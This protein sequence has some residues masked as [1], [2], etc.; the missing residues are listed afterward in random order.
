MAEDR[1]RP[2]GDSTLTD[3]RWQAE[4][5]AVVKAACRGAELGLTVGT[6][7]NVSARV[8]DK[9]FTITPTGASYETMKWDDIVVV[10]HDIEPVAGEGIPSS[11]SLLHSTIYQRRPDIGAVIH[12]HSTYSSVLAVTGQ[13]IPPILDEMVVHIGGAIGVSEYAFPAT[14][15]LA[16]NV[17]EALGD[18]NAAIIRNHGAVAVGKDLDEALYVCQ[19]VE[20]AAH[21]FVY[22]SLLGEASVLPDESVRAEKAIFRMRMQ[23]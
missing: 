22:A 8:S 7:G 19:L 23:R 5:E 21:V 11:E 17:F 2:E 15:Q 12:S 6:S 13:A 14:E 18:R 16:S 1:N 10:D 9:L 3:K 4:R 20:R